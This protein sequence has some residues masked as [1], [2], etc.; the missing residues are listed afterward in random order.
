MRI[1][2]SMQW[3]TEG[4]RLFQDAVPRFSGEETPAMT[5]GTD[6]MDTVRLRY[7]RPLYVAVALS[8]LGEASLFVTHGIILYPA[9][10]LLYKL[11]WT[12]VFCGIGMGATIGAFLDLFVVGRLSGGKAILAST[13]FTAVAIGGVCNLLCLSLDRRF[14]YFGGDAD[15]ALF[16]TNGL[17][18]ATLGG[19]VIGWLLFT[20]RG[21][22][23]LERIGI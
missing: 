12:F 19:A 11:L 10:T 21:N 16:F 23:L 13:A 8:V 14:H 9:G 2:Q 20:V 22:R 6:T 7:L 5:S 4:T 15:P 18:L 17:V 3:G 1:S